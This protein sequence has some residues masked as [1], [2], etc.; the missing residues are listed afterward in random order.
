MTEHRR[1]METMRHS[2]PI[3]LPPAPVY[4]D[5]APTGSGQLMSP[6]ATV[7]VHSP[8]TNATSPELLAKLAVLRHSAEKDRDFLQDEQ[9]FLATLKTAPYKSFHTT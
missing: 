2:L 1:E 9:F 6:L 3:H 5:F 8:V 7:Q 4:T